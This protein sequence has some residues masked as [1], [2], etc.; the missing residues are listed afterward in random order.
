MILQQENNGMSVTSTVDHDPDVIAKQVTYERIYSKCTCPMQ[1]MSKYGVIFPKVPMFMTTKSHSMLTWTISV[2]LVRVERLWKAV[3]ESHLCTSKCHGWMLVFL[4]K[5]CFATGVRYQ[6]K[7]DPFK[8]KYVSDIDR[9]CGKVENLGGLQ[10]FFQDI[11]GVLCFDRTQSNWDE[12]IAETTDVDY[13]IIIMMNCQH[14]TE[15]FSTELKVGNKK[16]E[17]LTVVGVGRNMDASWDGEIYSRHGGYYSSW[18]YDDRR[19]TIPIQKHELPDIDMTAR[20]EYVMVYGIVL[21]DPFPNTCSH[22]Y[23]NKGLVHQRNQHIYIPSIA[24]R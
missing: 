22:A 21:L 7:K 16:F 10:Y 13:N 17:L 11:P 20:E 15:T 19:Q 2:L 3:C 4:H 14:E 24:L 5:K 9:L 12:Y 18:W 6:K 1:T 8:Y 23:V